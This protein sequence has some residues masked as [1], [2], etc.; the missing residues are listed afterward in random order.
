M[1]VGLR[2]P[3]LRSRQAILDGREHGVTLDQA[4]PITIP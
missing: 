3:V 2:C 1:A 4:G